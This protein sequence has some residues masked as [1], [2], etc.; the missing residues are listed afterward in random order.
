MADPRALFIVTGIVVLA[1]IVFVVIVLL[2]APDE[3][4]R[5]EAKKKEPE[6]KKKEP[7]QE[8]EPKIEK[9]ADP[10]SDEVEEEEEATGPYAL[11]LVNAIGR[12]DPGLVR[13][14]N[15][16]SLLISDRHHLFVVADGMGRHAAGE[17]ASQLAVAAIAEAFEKEQ[18]DEPGDKTP[19]RARR[20]KRA[21]ELANRRVLEKSNEV[22]DYAGMGTTVVAAYFSPN[23]QRVYLAHVGDSRCYR[24]RGA[25]LTQLT[26]DHTLGAAGIEGRAASMLSRA[27]GVEEDIAVDVSVEAPLPGDVYLLCSDGLTRMA[28]EEEIREI[29]RG[30]KEL[31]RAATKLVEKAKSEGG[32]DNITVILVRVDAA[33]MPTA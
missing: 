29:V 24:V 21:I 27:V 9:K 6:E 20:L 12:T 7:A 30:E 10:P 16:D 14:N 31:A 33:S 17:V 23:K 8:E 13:K 19:K 3:P 15:E 32:R 1:L 28:K 22:P 18:A 11:I 4:P 25:A 2:R 5:E 26:S